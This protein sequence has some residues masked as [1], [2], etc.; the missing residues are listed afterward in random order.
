MSTMQKMGKRALREVGKRI[1]H[2]TRLEREARA[3]VNRRRF[4]N[5]GFMILT[6]ACV[7]DGSRE[8][9][10]GI[11]AYG[12]C[13][14]DAIVP[15]GRELRRQVAGLTS[16]VHVGDIAIGRS[17]FIL[18]GLESPPAAEH[19]A[20]VS[21]LLNLDDDHFA[22]RLFEPNFTVPNHGDLGE[23]A[24]NVVVLSIAPDMVRTMYRHR[25]HGYLLDPG[26][27]WLGSDMA[28]VLGDLDK[29]KW[30]AAN[31]KKLGRIKVED[32]L[33]NFERIIS[34]L[35]TRVGAEVLVA[36]AL[37]VDPGITTFDYRLSHSPHTSR[38]REFVL[39]LIDLS[40]KLDFPVLDIDS[41]TKRDGVS[42]MGDFVHYTADQ[43]LTI[44]RHV[45]E[46]LVRTGMVPTRTHA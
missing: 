31:F 37:V 39:G 43:R 20:E 23:F 30:F 29:V 18:Q 40:R 34:L 13:D 11:Y 9:R 45:A 25:E 10:T 15:A 7:I 36:N 19:I 24:K 1:G 16:V 33:A 3:F 32:A 35:R 14:L 38:R 46:T 17:D 6:D 42:G 41:L 27:F 2:K 4:K 44:G 28:T 8:H 5:D 12:G 26:G 21:E 22:A